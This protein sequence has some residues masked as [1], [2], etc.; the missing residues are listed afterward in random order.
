MATGQNF[1]RTYKGI[2][3]VK[4]YNNQEGVAYNLPVPLDMTIMNGTQERRIP[5]RNLYGEQVFAEAF[6]NAR[7]PML[8]V[9]FPTLPLEIVEFQTEH[10]FATKTMAYTIPRTYEVDQ[11]TPNGDGNIVLPLNLGIGVAISDLKVSVTG[12]H[13]SESLTLNAPV[14]TAP[15]AALATG[16]GTL[17]STGTSPNL[18]HSLYLL[19]ADFIGVNAP[20]SAT[21][22]VLATVSSE[23][24]A[25]SESLGKD[26]FKMYANVVTSE[27]E[28]AVITVPKCKPSFQNTQ[29][30][31]SAEQT[32]VIFYIYTPAGQCKPYDIIHTGITVAC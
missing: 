21:I 1:F 8:R 15:N 13:L 16:T 20:Y 2:S 30:A 22:T 19:G 27:N 18:V 14:T 3:E 11:L 23:V 7:D 12:T 17:L 4:L 26:T 32:E 25:L 10:K 5:T 28:L 29:F 31:P 24:T 9:I 6:T